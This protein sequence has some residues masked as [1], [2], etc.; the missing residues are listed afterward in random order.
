LKTKKVNFL[1]VADEADVSKATLYNNDEIIERIM[2][3]RSIKTGT[4]ARDSLLLKD[5]IEAERENV[6]KQLET[7]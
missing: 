3:L 4:P 1:T 7:E 5:G 6:R 2:S